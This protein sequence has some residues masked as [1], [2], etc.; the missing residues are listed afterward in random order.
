MAEE[1]TGKPLNAK[2][3][4]FNFI[5]EMACIAGFDGYFKE[6][7]PVWSRVLGW[8]T[9]ELLSRPWNDFVHPD[10][11]DATNSVAATIVDG[12]E[13]YT[14]ENRFICKDGTVKWLSWNSR[15]Y[16]EEGIMFGVARDITHRKRA[17]ELL[18]KSKNRSRAFLDVSRKLVEAEY[19]ENIMQ[20]IVDNALDAM[21]FATGAI[22][23]LSEDRQSVLLKAT[24]PPLP[25]DFPKGLQIAGLNDHPHIKKVIQT[26]KYVLIPDTKKVK[27]TKQEE[28][29]VRLRDIRSNLYLPIIFSDQVTGVLIISSM[30][31]T[32]TFE[33]EE[34][35]LMQG[36]ADQF[37]HII[38]NTQNYRQLESKTEELKK[39][40]ANRREAEKALRESE[41]R[42]REI[43]ETLPVISVQGYDSNRNVIYW[44]KASEDLYGYSRDEAIGQKLEDL[45]IPDEM[46]DKVVIDIQNWV[47]NNIPVPSSEL[48]LQKKDGSKVYVYSNHVLLKNVHGEPE[49]FCIDIDLSDLKEIEL[50]LRESELYHRSLIQTIPDTVFV[51]D[52]D[53]NF[54]DVKYS[55][56][57]NL[58]ME[59]SQ[60]LGRSVSEIMPYEVAE[61]QMKAAKQCLVEQKVVS[62][63]YSIQLNGETRYLNARNVAFGEDK[64]IATVRDITDYQENLARIKQL[65]STQ[66][67]QNEKLRNFT[68]IVSHNLRS[69]TANMHGILSLLHMEEPEIFNNPY[70]DLI[71]TCTENLN[72]TIVNLNEVLDMSFG[73]LDEKTNINLHKT[74]YKAIISVSTLAQDS[75]VSLYNEIEENV[76]IKS[77]P[78]YIDS[79][80][81][82]MLT[83][84]I[85]FHRADADS[86][87]KV[88]CNRENSYLA[89]QFEDNGVGIDLSLHQEKLFG[90]YK[91]FHEHVESKGLGLFITKNQVEVMGG[92]IDVESEVNKGTTFTIY[93]PVE[94][95]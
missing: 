2:E 29:I 10:D 73:E 14:F 78:V 54:L 38:K 76:T 13:V 15:P 22:Y 87:V 62:F 84:G 64:V 46:R 74:I 21:G 7:N 41:K 60:F 67:K 37:A 4:F 6:L 91:T 8:S 23:I 85:K 77:Y 5:T 36:F 17:D 93:L 35:D 66:E 59:P 88:S 45:I 34:I 81:L 44:N 79:I 40:I 3:L 75:G 24:T 70:L 72:E 47:D 71:R 31:E 20:T 50:K 83:N 53:N 11:I 86:Y 16:P 39:E 27:L 58:M 80:V 57:K 33:D 28:N 18:Q 9:E 61:Q 63:D 89:I 12:E 42:F 55:N 95:V 56:E 1:A 19:Q 43:F 68:H 52:K 32:Y 49:M 82:N 65:L 26:G 69:H 92:Y 48:I 90:M 51:F 25:G 94:E 30:S